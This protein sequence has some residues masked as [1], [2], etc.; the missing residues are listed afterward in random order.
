M[1]LTKFHILKTKDGSSYVKLINWIRIQNKELGLAEAVEWVQSLPQIFGPV[2]AN[3]ETLKESLSAL[4][5]FELEE[6]EEDLSKKDLLES[7]SR[8]WFHSLNEDE[9][10]KF[11]WCCKSFHENETFRKEMIETLSNSDG[12]VK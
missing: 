2:D 4:A 3:V 5:E 10:K 8:E 12:N 1:K 6:Y 9:R 11:L 7:D